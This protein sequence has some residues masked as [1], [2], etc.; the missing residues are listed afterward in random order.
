M[1]YECKNTWFGPAP[2]SSDVESGPSFGMKLKLSISD[3]FTSSC[4]ETDKPFDWMTVKCIPGAV[5]AD[6]DDDTEAADANR[7]ACPIRNAKM[8]CLNLA[9]KPHLSYFQLRHICICY[10]I[11]S[12]KYRRRGERDF[13]H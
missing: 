5:V 6:E 13:T 2:I 1:D 4:L 3:G 10:Y 11:Y 12:K 9:L 8:V 7:A